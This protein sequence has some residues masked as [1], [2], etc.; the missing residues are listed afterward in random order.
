MFEKQTCFWSAA[1]IVPVLIT[2][3]AC[4]GG[5]LPAGEDRLDLG[6]ASSGCK[7]KGAKLCAPDAGVKDSGGGTQPDAGTP[8]TGP[9]TPPD[10]GQN[11]MLT[12][13]DAPNTF[14]AA[15]PP[16]AASGGQQTWFG[17]GSLDSTDVDD[18]YKVPV[19]AGTGLY[20]VVKPPVGYD[21]VI[22]GWKTATGPSFT[23]EI[24][25]PSGNAVQVRNGSAAALW[26]NLKIGRAHV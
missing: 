17:T 13:G 3:G 18:Y 4:S 10:A 5:P 20:A 11:D 6:E 16:Q 23:I 9:G 7:A 19:T 15:V 26:D 25:D 21:T 14:A 24:L 8:D 22:P 12:G 1:S 2:M